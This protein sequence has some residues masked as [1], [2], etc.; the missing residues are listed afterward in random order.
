MCMARPDYHGDSGVYIAGD[1]E[2]T[3]RKIHP[4][5]LDAIQMSVSTRTAYRIPSVANSRRV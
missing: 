3:L 4:H 1:E 5:D 2:I